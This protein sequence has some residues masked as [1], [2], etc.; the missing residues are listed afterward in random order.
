LTDTAFC[1]YRFY[2]PFLPERWLTMTTALGLLAAFACGIAV[3]LILRRIPA[4]PK[5]ILMV[6]AREFV[7][8]VAI[9]RPA[10]LSV[11][12]FGVGTPHARYRLR[13]RSL[14]ATNEFCE[15]E[16]GRR[17]DDPAS[18]RMTR[19]LDGLLEHVR[20]CGYCEEGGDDSAHGWVENPADALE[21]VS[22]AYPRIVPR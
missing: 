6:D 5:S 17:R 19:L 14:G 22:D 16:L 18:R 15:T 3:T 1:R 21:R 11:R 10:T 4:A 20:W 9:E 8:R 13:F 7:D 2:S 12:A